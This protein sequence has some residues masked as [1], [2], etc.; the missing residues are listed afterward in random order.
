M[1]GR[2]GVGKEVKDRSDWGGGR[3]G[4][5]WRGRLMRGATGESRGR[6]G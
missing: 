2:G 1:R 6:V 3:E 4:D 5:G